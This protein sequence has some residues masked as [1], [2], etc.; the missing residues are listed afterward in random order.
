MKTIILLGILGATMSTPLIPQLLMSASNSNELLLNLNNAQLQ[1]LQLQG[2]FNSWIPPFPGI[3]QQQQQAQIPGLCHFSLSTLDRFAG[4]VPNQ[5]PFPGQVSFAQETQAGQLDPSQ[6]QTPP[7][8][9]QGPNNISRVMPSVFSFKMPHE[10]AQMLLYYPVYMLLPWEQPQ[11]TVA[12]SPP[13]TGQLL[14]EEQMPFYTEF[15]YIPQQAEPVMP[16]GQQQLAFD[17]FLGTNPEI[18]VMVT[19][20]VSPYLQKEM[21]NFK[22]ANAGIFIPSTSQKPSTANVFTSAMDPTIT[23]ELMEKKAKTNSLKEP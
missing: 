21:I 9:Q 16:R 11:Q 8:T 6:P 5:I 17:P 1:P 19:G 12:Q 20:G 10:Q 14:F 22:H 2:L 3:L 13:Q 15:G 7:Q 4:L 23:P 18:A